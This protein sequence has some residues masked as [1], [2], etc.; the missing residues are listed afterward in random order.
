MIQSVKEAKNHEKARKKGKDMLTEE[1]EY[2]KIDM[3]QYI[4]AHPDIWDEIMR[5]R[6]RDKIERNH[7]HA[8]WLA[9]GTGKWTTHYRDVNGKR[10]TLQ[11]A[12]KEALIDKLG[13]LYANQDN[14]VTVNHVFEKWLQGKVDHKEVRPSTQ[15]RYLQ[16]YNRFFIRSGMADRPIKPI[17]EGEIDDFLKDEIIKE[18]LTAKTFNGLKILVTGIWK[19]A[20]RHGFTE[21]SIREV[22]DNLE[23]SRKSFAPNR[24]EPINEIF[25]DDELKKVMDYLRANPDVLNRAI[26]LDF[27]TGLRA[28]ELVALK[29]TDFVRGRYLHIQRTETNIGG[30]GV[31]DQPKTDAGN[32]EV[33]LSDEAV[34]VVTQLIADPELAGKD[35]M[36]LGSQNHNRVIRATLTKRLNRICEQVGITRKRFHAIRKTYATNLIDNQVS[37]NIITKQL[38]HKDIA[39]TKGFYYLLH[40]TDEDQAIQLED[41]VKTMGA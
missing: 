23:I 41:A 17:T 14:Q 35:W 10:K 9:P 27:L 28:G 32:R 5:Q 38:G 31:L 34:S 26:L 7:G 8:I 19:Y 25:T 40:Q 29:K 1:T 36:F 22:L 13:E 33:Y 4:L 16:D 6:V 3:Q 12:T 24:Y 15:L 2:D 18:N 21:L 11:Y 30:V 37:E 39:T 20:R